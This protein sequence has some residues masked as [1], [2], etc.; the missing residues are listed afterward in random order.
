[1]LGMAMD[2]CWGWQAHRAVSPG[3]ED[4]SA[5]DACAQ[6]IS[7]SISISMAL[8]GFW[9]YIIIY[10]QDKSDLVLTTAV[11]QSAIHLTR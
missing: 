3:A 5:C 6:S 4:I 7:Q 11:R 9:S 1:M 2:Q 10:S 8:F